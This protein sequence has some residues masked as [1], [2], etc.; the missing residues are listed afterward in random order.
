MPRT[1]FLSLSPEGDPR[2]LFLFLT[3][4]T[5][6]LVPCKLWGTRGDQKAISRGQMVSSADGADVETVS[7]LWPHYNRLREGAAALR[8]EDIHVFRLLRSPGYW[9][10]KACVLSRIQLFPTPWTVARQAPWSMGF[11]RQ[12]YWSGL[13]FPPLEDL[14]NPGIEPTSPVSPALAAGL[15][16]A[17]WEAPL[18][19]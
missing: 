10:K 5:S 1:S 8:S 17:T 6:F 4:M 9:G 19:C 16:S 15:F 18:G 14:P 13:P 12:K 2:S 3:F 7:I 11:S